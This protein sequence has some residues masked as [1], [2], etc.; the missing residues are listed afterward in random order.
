[1]PEWLQYLLAAYL[2]VGIADNFYWMT[3]KEE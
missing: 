1:M 3:R 2:L